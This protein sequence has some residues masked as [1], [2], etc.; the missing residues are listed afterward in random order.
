VE[1]AVVPADPVNQKMPLA[2]IVSRAVPITSLDDDDEVFAKPQ[3]HESH[4]GKGDESDP[5]VLAILKSH[6]E[7]Q[8]IFDKARLEREQVAFMAAIL[9][10]HELSEQVFQQLRFE[11]E[12]EQ[13]QVQKNMVALAQE[14]ARLHENLE[15]IFAKIGK[16]EEQPDAIIVPSSPRPAGPLGALMEELKTKTSVIDPTEVNEDDVSGEV[17]TDA[18]PSIP[19]PEIIA[20]SLEVDSAAPSGTPR[21]TSD[22]S[23]LM[24]DELKKAF[25][26]A[27]SVKS[28]EGSEDEVSAEDVNI[29]PSAIAQRRESPGLVAQNDSGAAEA[30]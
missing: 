16:E 22:S 13:L 15:Q 18:S 14:A 29:S 10:S 30:H 7:A 21:K 3:V 6:M 27:L 12:A 24:L 9:Q 8:E 28:T 4:Q 17:E 11:K 25:N 23:N 1:S 5:F 2:R 20:T 26:E 19:V